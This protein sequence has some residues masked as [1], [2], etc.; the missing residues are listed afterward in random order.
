MFID[1]LQMSLLLA[2]FLF[3]IHFSK[4]T[5]NN[6]ADLSLKSY[7]PLAQALEK[8]LN[9]GKACLK[10]ASRKGKSKRQ[11]NAQ[12]EQSAFMRSRRLSITYHR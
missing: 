9:M 4:H 5:F 1:N 2:N 12:I 3:S 8:V 10:E 7:L 6:M 11:E